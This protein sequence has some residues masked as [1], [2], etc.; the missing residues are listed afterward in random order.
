MIILVI[1]EVQQQKERTHIFMEN[2]IQANLQ[3]LQLLDH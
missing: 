3:L 1:V 2:L